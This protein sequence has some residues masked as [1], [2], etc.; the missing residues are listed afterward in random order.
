VCFAAFAAP[1]PLLASFC[2]VPAVHRGTT[3]QCPVTAVPPR[4]A[5]PPPFATTSRTL[6]ASMLPEQPDPALDRRVEPDLAISA[7]NPSHRRTETAA[8]LAVVPL[9]WGSYGVA[10]KL[11]FNALPGVPVSVLNLSGYVVAVASLLAVRLAVDRKQVSPLAKVDNA[12]GEGACTHDAS[13]VATYVSAA[14]LGAYLFFGSYAQ[15]VGLELTSA[16]RSALLV[17]LTTV[18]V[19]ALDVCVLGVTPNF[20]LF[21]AA[22]AAVLGVVVLG[23]DP[24]TSPPPHSAL[25]EF[26]ARSLNRGDLLSILAAFLYTVHVLRLQVI[27][28]RTPSVLRL[29]EAKSVVQALLASFAVAVSAQTTFDIASI[30]NIVLSSSPRAV[31]TA[32]TCVAWIG[33]LTTAAATAA[34]VEGQRR[35]GPSLAAVVYSSQPAFAAALAIALLHDHLSRA[36][37]VGGAIVVLAGASVAFPVNGNT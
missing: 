32:A 21:A 34:Q 24:T 16:S 1:M 18:M 29:V 23:L 10:V 22:V 37:I 19:P 8:L 31:L 15:L 6:R 20:R 13:W 27:S 3:C 2:V 14:E 26:S 35:V 7:S 36:E 30:R 12:R 25:S 28:L 5:S 17:Q 9:L 33:A 4:P 11:F